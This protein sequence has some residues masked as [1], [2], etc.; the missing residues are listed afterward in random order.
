MIAGQVELTHRRPPFYT[1][2]KDYVRKR[3][4]QTKEMFV[5]LSHPPGHAQCDFGKAPGAGACTGTTSWDDPPD[6][7]V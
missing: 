5:P 1:T 3:R 2:V 4:R 7:S 6:L